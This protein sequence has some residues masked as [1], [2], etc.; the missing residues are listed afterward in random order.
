MTY[1]VTL[2]AFH[3]YAWSI[4]WRKTSLWMKMKLQ[5][6]HKSNESHQSRKDLEMCESSSHIYYYDG[7]WSK[8]DMMPL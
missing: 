5:I 6:D 3:G 7:V 4:S 2:Y 8:C 1:S